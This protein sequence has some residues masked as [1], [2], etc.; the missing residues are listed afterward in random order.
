MTKMFLEF[1][2]RN[3]MLWPCVCLSVARQK[4][5]CCLI[6]GE[7]TVLE[8]PKGSLVRK[9]RGTQR[10]ELGLN[11]ELDDMKRRNM[12]DVWCVVRRGGVS[13]DGDGTDGRTCGLHALSS[14][15]GGR[16]EGVA[17]G[18]LGDDCRPGRLGQS[19]TRRLD[20]V[21]CRSRSPR[22]TQT[23]PARTQLSPAATRRSVSCSTSYYHCSISTYSCLS[24]VIYADDDIV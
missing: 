5:L 21:C 10:F 4:N 22:V 19:S 9:I 23:R 20:S 13:V 12:S 1:S 17:C 14:P 18:R 3:T 8:E 2:S 7:V 11:V 15:A 16:R 6:A 24:S